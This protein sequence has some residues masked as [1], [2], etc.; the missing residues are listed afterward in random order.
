M[1]KVQV[2]PQRFLASLE[3]VSAFSPRAGPKPILQSVQM[4]ATTDG[5][6]L[7]RA[8]DLDAFIALELAHHK[9]VEPGAVQLPR[10]R[11]RSLLKQA[12]G[13]AAVIEALPPEELPSSRASGEP[14]RSIVVR[15]E[16][17]TTTLPTFD[18]EHFPVLPT[19]PTTGTVALPPGG[20]CSSSSA[21]GSPPTPCPPAMPSEAPPSSLPTASSTSWPP[22]GVACPM[23]RRPHPAPGFGPSPSDGSMKGPR[24][25]LRRSRSTP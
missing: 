20:W 24:V 25:S 7:L 5:Q 18:P 8:T 2:T 22:T 17:S 12:R 9:V 13:T 6:V 23:P 15:S 4:E 14:S 16:R 11:V 21:P 19:E 3:A 10:G 1:L